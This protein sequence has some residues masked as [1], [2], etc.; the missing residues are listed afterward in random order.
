MHLQSMRFGIFPYESIKRRNSIENY[1]INEEYLK[2]GT[3]FIKKPKLQNVDCNRNQRCFEKNIIFNIFKNCNTKEYTNHVNPSSVKTTVNA[4]QTLSTKQGNS[5][6]KK[7]DFIEDYNCSLFEWSDWSYHTNEVKY[8]EVEKHTSLSKLNKK[9]ESI[10]KYYKVFDFLPQKLNNLAQFRSI[11]LIKTPSFDNIDT[12]IFFNE[13]TCNYE[14]NRKQPQDIDIHPC[15]FTQHFCEFKLQRTA[16]EFTKVLNQV[17][18]Q[19]IAALMIYDNVELL[20]M[21]DQHA[22]H[23]RIRYENL[24]NGYRTSD[25]NNFLTKKL[26]I[27]IR[28]EVKMHMCTLFLSN[29]KSLDKYGIKLTAINENT[30]SIYSIPKCFTTNKHYYNDVKLITTIQNLLNEIADNITNGN[31]INILPLSIHN[32][33]SMEACHGIYY[34]Y[35]LV[36]LE[37]VA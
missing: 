3:F 6:E 7:T 15:A 8:N 30:L 13:L 22:V 4:E 27:P 1:I 36:I 2:T 18:N 35:K 21:M 25:H 17:N 24:L 37:K 31:G 14:E 11:K 33:V 16:L 34:L 19:L 23:E 28:I 26:P 5:I 10:E 29:K 32:A 12:S 9:N 20:L